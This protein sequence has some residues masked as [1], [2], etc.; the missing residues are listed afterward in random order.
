MQNETGSVLIIVTLLAAVLFGFVGLVIE[1]GRLHLLRTET[2]RAADAAV[3]AAV[4]AMRRDES[5]DQAVDDILAANAPRSGQFITIGFL[6]NFA[7]QEFGIVLRGEAPVIF[8]GFLGIPHLATEK[9]SV[10]KHLV[11][12]GPG[13]DVLIK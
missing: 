8:G 1:T 7:E 10:A 9:H 2:V 11:W 4:G 6:P 3:L 5:I 13:R 12:P